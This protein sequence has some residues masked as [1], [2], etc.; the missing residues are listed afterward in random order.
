MPTKDFEAHISVD[1]ETAGPNPS[2]YSLLSIGAC[3]VCD[4]QR[5]FYVELQPVNDNFLPS[6]LTISVKVRDAPHSR[7]I[8]RK[9]ASDHPARGESRR[10]WFNRRPGKSTGFNKWR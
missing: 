8:D 10:L 4:P 6:A 7:Q 3:M 1:V 5:T 9:A 2:Q